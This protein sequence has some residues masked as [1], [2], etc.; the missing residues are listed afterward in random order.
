MIFSSFWRSWAFESSSKLLI[1]ELLCFQSILLFLLPNNFPSSQRFLLI[2]KGFVINHRYFS[3]K[4]LFPN[5]PRCILF[6]CWTHTETPFCTSCLI[7]FTDAL[8][9]MKFVGFSC[10]CFSSLP[11]YDDRKLIFI[12]E[13]TSFINIS[14]ECTRE[15]A[16]KNIFSSAII[17]TQS[18]KS[19][20]CVFGSQIY[21]SCCWCA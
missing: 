7:L 2:F 13:H 8:F 6:R 21:F 16:T 19:L 5:S 11:A 9:F 1:F 3:R 14:V 12:W 17:F 10:C 4:K 15:K 20:L 18:N